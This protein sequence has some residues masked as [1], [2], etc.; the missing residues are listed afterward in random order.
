MF[1][2]KVLINFSLFIGGI[3]KMNGK[4]EISRPRVNCAG[5]SCGSWGYQIK[6]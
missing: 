3:Y 1:Y 5:E 4:G 2:F 6:V